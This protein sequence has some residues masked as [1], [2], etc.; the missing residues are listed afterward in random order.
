MTQIHYFI[1]KHSI[2]PGNIP[3][4]WELSSISVFENNVVPLLAEIYKTMS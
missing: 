3:N 2:N 4:I 1:V